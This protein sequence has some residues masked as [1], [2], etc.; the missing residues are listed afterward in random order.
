M[1]LHINVVEVD[2][3]CPEC[4]SE[5]KLHSFVGRCC[6]EGWVLLCNDEDFTEYELVGI[7]LGNNLVLAVCTGEHEHTESESVG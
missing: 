4:E 3:W 2:K 5:V 1:N 6:E 7:Y